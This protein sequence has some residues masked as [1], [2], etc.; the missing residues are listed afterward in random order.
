[1]NHDT[2]PKGNLSLGIFLLAER[3]ELVQEKQPK[4]RLC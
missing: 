1:M 3:I 4:P 2:I